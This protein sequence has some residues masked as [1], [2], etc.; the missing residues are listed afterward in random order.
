M[1]KDTTR[2]LLIVA[3]LL[4]LGAG[5]W[6]RGCFIPRP[7]PNAT[8]TII[9]DTTI[10]RAKADTIRTRVDHFRDVT[11]MVTDTA[12]IRRARETATYY[13]ERYE[14]LVL[15]TGMREYLQWTADSCIERRIVAGTDTTTFTDCI[16]VS[17]NEPP[18]GTFEIRTDD[19]PIQVPT[20][21]T[22]PPTWIEEA[23]EWLKSGLAVVGLAAVIA[24]IFNAT[25]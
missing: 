25:R 17:F 5:A 23:W 10:I 13:R 12:A 18:L 22:V 24:V 4:T 2:Y 21:A 11:Q 3:F 1:D 19:A 16:H 9:R 20:M 6:L 8:A 7:A 15:E 14:A